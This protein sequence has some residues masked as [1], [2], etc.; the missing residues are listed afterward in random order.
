[1]WFKLYI[2]HICFWFLFQYIFFCA[3]VL[4]IGNKKSGSSFYAYS[5]LVFGA[6]LAIF[7][8]TLHDIICSLM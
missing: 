7:S 3:Y 4:L 8:A 1:M 5:H 6:I 2:A